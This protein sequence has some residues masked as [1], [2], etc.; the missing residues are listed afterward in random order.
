MQI[1]IQAI[2]SLFVIM[3]GVL[4]IAGDFKE[5]KA[6]AD[7]ENKSWDTFR[8][9]SSFYVFNHRGKVFSPTYKTSMSASILD[10]AD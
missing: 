6:S 9:V 10:E 1:T 7:L 2:V 8:N 3:Y 5:I 4:Y